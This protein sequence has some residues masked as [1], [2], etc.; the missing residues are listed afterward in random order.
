MARRFSKTLKAIIT[1]LI[2]IAAI[3][4]VITVTGM[5]ADR[6]VLGEVAQAGEKAEA[7]FAHMVRGEGGN[8][9]DYYA[10]AM[11]AAEDIASDGELT[12]YLDGEKEAA[13]EL[14]QAVL[15]NPEIIEYL[16]EGTHQE[17]CMAPHDYAKGLGSPLPE[18]IALRHA[19]S[20]AC[21]KALYDLE[22]GRSDDAIALLFSVMIVGK[23]IASSPMIIDQMIGFA[24]V[25]RGMRVL[26]IGIASRAFNKRQLGEIAE[27]L[28][29]LDKH[30]PMLTDAIVGDINLMRISFASY[31]ERV[32]SLL[33]M[34]DE[35][36][37]HL[38]FVR[39][40]ALRVLCWRDWFSPIRA[41]HSSL[42]FFEALEDDLLSY[43][44]VLLDETA[45]QDS[46]K[47]RLTS[48]ERGIDAFRKRNIWF[49]LSCPEYTSLFKQKVEWL[50]TVRMLGLS[51]SLASH[52][53]VEGGFP[54][55]LAEIAPHLVVDLRT[56]K[57]W[58]YE[59][60]GDSA[61]I[62]STDSDGLD[63]LSITVTKMPIEE[64]L[65]KIRKRAQEEHR[66]SKEKNR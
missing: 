41:I 56:G 5:I 39:L 15:D 34:G 18:Y 36:A 66:S 10:R 11:E 23:H 17:Y 48:I 3:I 25:G 20:I 13:P 32:T 52:R 33:V 28:D 65:A 63:T 49:A 21:V 12:G 7:Y 27:F 51:S 43:E 1:I 19:A 29:D 9:W 6:T 54:E 30:W 57:P 64:Y 14:I 55:A 47:R 46:V 44:Q 62:M 31:G 42:S 53:E 38:G 4:I 61:R 50:T 60:F 16:Q 59:N 58:A 37:G 2:V 24:M 35:S 8:A 22:N 40:F 26:K 45:S